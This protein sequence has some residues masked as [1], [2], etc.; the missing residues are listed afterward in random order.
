MAMLWLDSLRVNSNLM[1]VTCTGSPHLAAL[2]L[3][4]LCNHTLITLTY[5]CPV[6][7]IKALQISLFAI[8][9]RCHTWKPTE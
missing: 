5:V 6:Y 3:V 2:Y 4:E 9:N 7:L 1:K 8:S